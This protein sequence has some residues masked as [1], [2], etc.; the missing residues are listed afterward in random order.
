MG[1]SFIE[2]HIKE[3]FMY[4]VTEKLDMDLSTYVRENF[5]LMKEHHKRHIFLQILEGVKYCHDNDIMHRD[6]K[7][8]NIVVSVD[9]NKRI[10]DLKIADL[11]IACSIKENFN[12]N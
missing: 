5:K 2:L 7:M 12:K 3:N 10:Y 8:D 11:G 4:I 1:I 9:Q 6:L